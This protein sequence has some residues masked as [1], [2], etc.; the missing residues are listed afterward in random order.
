MGKDRLA[1]YWPSPEPGYEEGVIARFKSLQERVTGYP[2][3]MPT[4][5]DA[6]LSALQTTKSLSDEVEVFSAPTTQTREFLD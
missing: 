4:D 6:D 1:D 3:W 2:T 5:V